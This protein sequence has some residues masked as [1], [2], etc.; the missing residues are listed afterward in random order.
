MF[1]RFRNHLIDV[2]NRAF[3][4]FED[5]EL[6]EAGDLANEYVDLFERAVRP[7][8]TIPLKI[9]EPGW[10]STGY[11][12]ADVLERDGPIA[13]RSGMQMFWNHQTAYEEMERPEGD[14]DN[15]AAVLVEDAEY[16]ANGVAGPGLY[17]SARVMASYQAAVDDLAPHIGVSIRARGRA[18]DGS[19]EG[20]SGRIIQSIDEGRSVDFV[21][22]PGAGGRILEMFES[23]KAKGQLL[24][25]NRQEEKMPTEQEFNDLKEA[26]STM[27]QRQQELEQ[28]LAERNNET[29]RL[30][31][32]LVERT[33]EA[34][35]R[36]N[37]A[38]STLPAITQQRLTVQLS[39]DLPVDDAGNLDEESLIQRV[40]EAAQAESEYLARVIDHTGDIRGFGRA[41]DPGGDR[42]QVKLQMAEA[43]A[44]MGMS[45]DAAKVAAAGRANR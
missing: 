22:K 31:E 16:D 6:T 25:H 21:T 27:Q 18:V 37:L 14:L 4:E 40:Q 35:I 5:E 41:A 13:F 7:D 28:Q 33:A 2:L 32:T 30:R 12:P 10:G 45:P 15:L 24:Q 20:R 44:A 39:S 19:A 36:E 26:F 11:Y 38:Q 23:A 8:G 1:E 34:V 29:D 17:A 43:F 3:D 9:I 42:E